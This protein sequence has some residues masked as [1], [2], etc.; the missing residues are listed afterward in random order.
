MDSGKTRTAQLKLKL[1]GFWSKY[2]VCLQ[3]RFFRQLIKID[4]TMIQGE[5]GRVESRID[6]PF[7]KFRIQGNVLNLNVVFIFVVRLKSCS[8]STNIIHNFFFDPPPTHFRLFLGL[9][10]WAVYSTSIALVLARNAYLM[11]T[12]FVFLSVDIQ[13]SINR[14]WVKFHVAISFSILF[15]ILNL[16][17]ELSK[18]MILLSIMIP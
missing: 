3:T 6:M 5:A 4:S 2:I 17:T 8:R 12:V 9:W 13:I 18:Y 10:W 11:K 16:W 7:L 15:L 14:Q 1:T